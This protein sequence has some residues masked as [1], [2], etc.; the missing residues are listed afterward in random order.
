MRMNINE[1]VAINISSL[2]IRKAYILVLFRIRMSNI[3]DTIKLLNPWWEDEMVSE[4]L[5]KRV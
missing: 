5:A 3:T 2:K 1:G 4:E